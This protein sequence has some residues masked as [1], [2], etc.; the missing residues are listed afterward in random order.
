MY[1][2]VGDTSLLI[3][4]SFFEIHNNTPYI[5]NTT[6]VYRNDSIM[7]ATAAIKGDSLIFNA[8]IKVDNIGWYFIPHLGLVTPDEKGNKLYH[9][10]NGSPELLCSN[11]QAPMQ[12]KINTQVVG[13]YYVSYEFGSNAI[14]YL[15]YLSCKAGTLDLKKLDSTAGCKVVYIYT[16]PKEFV[17]IT[18]DDY[19]IFNHNLEL[20]NTIK[21]APF[22]NNTGITPANITY[23]INNPVWGSGI[24][25]N[26]QGTLLNFEKNSS[27]FKQSRLQLANAVYLGK[28]NDSTSLW[29]NEQRKV[30]TILNRN[31]TLQRIPL[32]L[33][34][35]IKYK[36]WF[37]DT[38][39]LYSKG[40]VNMLSLNT[41]EHIQLSKFFKHIDVT[42]H[43]ALLGHDQEFLLAFLMGRGLKDLILMKQGVFY[44]VNSSS[45]GLHEYTFNSDKE[46]SY[47]IL[48]P[49]KYNKLLY[50]TLG[51]QLIAYSS[52]RILLYDLESYESKVLNY[53]QLSKQGINQILNIY[54]CSDDKFL[55]Q[56]FYK[57]IIC[58]LNTLESNRILNN[59]NLEGATVNVSNNILTVGNTFGICQ[60]NISNDKVIQE[61]LFLNPKNLLY[62]ELTGLCVYDNLLLINTDKGTFEID[63]TINENKQDD[64][65]LEKRILVIYNDSTRR[66]LV[67]DTVSLSQ[68]KQML[69]FDAVNATG[70]GELRFRYRIE[71]SSWVESNGQNISLLELATG[72]YYT[73]QIQ[74]YDDAWKSNI[75]NTRIYVIPYWWQTTKGKFLIIVAVLIVVILFLIIAITITKKQTERRNEK[76]NQQRDLELKSI[77]SQINPHF[78]FNTL[79]TAL[80]YIKKNKNDEAYTH[81]SQFSDLLRAYIKSSRNKYISIEDE[82]E[83]LK[84]YMQLQLSR[85]EEKFNYSITVDESIDPKNTQVPSLILQP[86]V[87]NALNH[88]IFHKENDGQINIVFKHGKHKREVICI[89]EDDGIG[90][91]K[92][93]EMRSNIIKKADSYGTILIKELV[94][95]FNK[96]EPIDIDIKYIDKELPKTGTTVIITINNTDHEKN[97]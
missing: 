70:L 80:Y 78:I 34:N 43:P 90:R 52:N 3:S 59:Y 77:Y 76:K 54:Q 50:D 12:A 83:N 2:N 75:I 28:Y 8:P 81:I 89:V 29:W 73:M 79:S 10:T 49:N 18:E 42:D 71:D 35:V 22:L 1:Q 72:R 63:L 64:T 96:Y 27:V 38:I 30:L 68:E 9:Y 58:N 7:Y 37:G 39:L 23:I 24:S 62:N 86:I 87:E 5:W 40:G 16:T 20:V 55:I 31:K 84:N 93:K 91:K 33:D 94:D 74:A 44:A 46:L 56:D 25:T 21:A 14:N 19:Y 48:D 26:N 45:V 36:Q 6:Y 11:L 15:N 53:N 32:N 17:V 61:K 47:K 67:D 88:G 13:N 82:I 51:N 65:Q 60:Y 69:T 92:S 57:L 4:P 41:Y 95:T 85:F 66:L 97:H